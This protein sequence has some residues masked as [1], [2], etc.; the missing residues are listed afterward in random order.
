MSLFGKKSPYDIDNDGLMRK[1]ARKPITKEAK[2]TA[3][4]LL[5]NTVLALLIYFGCVA[6]GFSAIFFIYIGAAAVLLIVYVIYN[7]GFVLRG[8][9]PEMLDAS[10]PLAERQKM[11]DQAAARYA[12]SR[13]MMTILIPLIVA[14]LLDAIY[15][16]FLADLIQ[17]V[18]EVLQ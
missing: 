11:I 14:V 1:K 9:T 12:S 18:S 4:L 5:M 6:L 17:L 13:W 3:W 10:L 7:Q 15:I 16:Y 8:A 2:K